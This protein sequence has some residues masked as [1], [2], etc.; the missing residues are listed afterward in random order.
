M[1]GV[2]DLFFK[3]DDIISV[4]QSERSFCSQNKTSRVALTAQRIALVQK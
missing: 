4:M 2:V 1:V 3:A